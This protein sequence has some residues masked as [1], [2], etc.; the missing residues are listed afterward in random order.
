MV[1]QIKVAMVGN[2]PSIYLPQLF[3]QPAVREEVSEEED[4]S[5]MQGTWEFADN[6]APEDAERVMRMM[7]LEGG[8]LTAEDVENPWL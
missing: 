2:D 5:D 4:L 6:I 1:H 7:L 3:P 8:T